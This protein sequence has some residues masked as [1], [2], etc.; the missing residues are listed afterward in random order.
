MRFSL[1]PAVLARVDLAKKLLTTRVWR[2]VLAV[3]LAA[4]PASA[5][6]LDYLTVTVE[7]DRAVPS[8]CLS[9]SADLPRGK[10]GALDP[11]VVLAPSV[12]HA[13][14][15]RGRDLCLSGL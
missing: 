5:F 11:Y 1:V 12:D 7:P 14:Q 9:F 3:G 6:A 8:A 4:A 10:A 2:L 15:A 13:L